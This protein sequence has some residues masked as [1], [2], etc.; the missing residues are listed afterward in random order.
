MSRLYLDISSIGSACG[1]MRFEPRERTLLFSWARYDP[2][3]CK[4]FLIENGYITIN[5]NDTD[6]FED[7]SRLVSKKAKSVSFTNTKVEEFNLIAKDIQNDLKQLRTNQ[8]KELTKGEINQFNKSVEKYLNTTFGKNSE[9]KI[10]SN[11]G[12]RA[13]NN[14][15]YYYNI[16]DKWCIGGKHDADKSDMV[17]EIKTRMKEV[18]VRKNEYDLYQIFGYLLAM[19]L[20]RGK[21]IQQ[22]NNKTFES[23]VETEKEYG[24][25]DSAQYS[26]EISIMIS[27]LEWFFERLEEIISSGKM[28]KE[29]LS[30]AIQDNDK[31]VCVI[32]NDEYINKKSK[33]SKL[34]LFI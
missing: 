22:Y 26:K 4:K 5:D 1:K 12:A 29:E 16:N 6:L 3:T 34:F 10:V 19:G 23:D 31:P 28:T 14:K 17:I 32:S 21:I 27:E 18:N 13:G 15:M 11:I 8:G 24:I 2:D 7:H 25:I 30:N 33:Y 20:R 9:E